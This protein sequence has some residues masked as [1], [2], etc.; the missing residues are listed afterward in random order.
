[1]GHLSHHQN[2]P[3]LEPTKNKQVFRIVA[4]SY[5]CDI[6]M[7]TNYGQSTELHIT[8]H[9]STTILR[10]KIRHATIISSFSLQLSFLDVAHKT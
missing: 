5:I 4:Q 3:W 2:M 1:M 8:V 6:K 10:P 9:S 7:C